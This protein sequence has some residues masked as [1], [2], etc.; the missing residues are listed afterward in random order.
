MG[1]L[2][3]LKIWVSFRTSLDCF[4]DKGSTESYK[5]R[6]SLAFCANNKNMDFQQR[7]TI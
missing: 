1:N 3:S 6:A 4:Y 7:T 2:G 5:V